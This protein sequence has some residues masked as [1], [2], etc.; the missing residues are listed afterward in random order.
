MARPIPRLA[1]VTTATDRSAGQESGLADTLTGIWAAV[2]SG[3]FSLNYVAD[4]VRSHVLQRIVPILLALGVGVSIGGT[5]T[6][7]GAALIATAAAA[8][9]ALHHLSD[10]AADRHTDIERPVSG[11]AVVCLRKV[12]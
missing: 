2:N 11:R 5:D 9:A 1:P 3:T 12:L 8:G 10:R 6:A 7:A 4:F